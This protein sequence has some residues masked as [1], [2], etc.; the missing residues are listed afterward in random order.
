MSE[1]NVHYDLSHNNVDHRRKSLV[2]ST[3]MTLQAIFHQSLTPFSLALLRRML[4]FSEYMNAQKR[5][6][7]KDQDEKMVF[8]SSAVEI[9][10]HSRSQKMS[11]QKHRTG[12]FV[13]CVA[14][15]IDFP[16]L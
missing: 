16:Y 3:Y 2:S 9:S 6:A 13:V 1:N 4:W 14:S 10:S 12:T 5:E 15:L 8:D 11:L 7:G